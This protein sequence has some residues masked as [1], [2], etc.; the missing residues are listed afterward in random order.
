MT[1]FYGHIPADFDPLLF[2]AMVPFLLLVLALNRPHLPLPRPVLF[3]AGV[4][5][6][7]ADG[8]QFLLDPPPHIANATAPWILLV[9]V[10]CTIPYL[11]DGIPRACQK[12]TR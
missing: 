5:L 10:L 12:Q 7:I 3:A 11:R 2:A 4:A 1:H 9:G 8:T 6:T